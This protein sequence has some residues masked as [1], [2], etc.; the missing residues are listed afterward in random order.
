MQRQIGN[1]TKID[2]LEN[3]KKS[4]RDMKDI[5][6][7]FK[8]SRSKTERDMK[9]RIELKNSRWLCKGRQSEPSRPEFGEL[10]NLRFSVTLDI[11]DVSFGGDRKKHKRSEFG[12]GKRNVNGE[13]RDDANGAQGNTSSVNSILPES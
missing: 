10:S 6:E 8:E 13:G 5:F 2:I 9:D 3:L 4:S 12:E 7:E 11:L 1:F